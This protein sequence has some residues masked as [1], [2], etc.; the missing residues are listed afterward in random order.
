MNSG[1]RVSL[2]KKITYLLLL[3]TFF[4]LM[5]LD[6]PQVLR[7]S[8]TSIVM[9]VT[10]AISTFAAVYIFGGFDTGKRKLRDVTNS[11]LLVHFMAVK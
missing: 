6:N 3:G 4:F 10:Y 1:F 11:L 8:R 2:I 9:L 7:L 5:S